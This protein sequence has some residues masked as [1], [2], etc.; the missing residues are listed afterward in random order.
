MFEDFSQKELFYASYKSIISLKNSSTKT[1][2][3][4]LLTGNVSLHICSIELLAW[5]HI[6]L[7]CL[8][9]FQMKYSSNQL[10][11]YQLPLCYN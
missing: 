3:N 7:K 2:A 11:V 8:F 9:I 1:Q 6:S 10:E 4:L 5:R